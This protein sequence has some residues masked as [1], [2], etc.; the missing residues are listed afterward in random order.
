MDNTHTQELISLDGESLTAEAVFRASRDSAFVA[1][2]PSSRE[3]MAASRDMLEAWVKEGRIMY[4]ITRGFGR[5][6]STLIPPSYQEELQKNLIRSHAAN[7]GSYFSK[8]E[9]RAAMLLRLN[10]FAKGYSAIRLETADLLLAFLNKGIH[11]RIPQWG[12]VGA[13]GDLNPSAHIA[14]SLMGEGEVEY[15]G[16]VM[17]AEAALSA[18]HLTPVVFRAKEGLALIN[19][20][21][22]MTGVGVLQIADAWALV[23]TAEILTALAIEALKGSREPF[24]SFAHLAKPH[25][26]RLPARPMLM[27]VWMAAPCLGQRELSAIQQ[28]LRTLMNEKNEV[29]DSV[30]SLQAAH[31]LRATPQILRAVRDALT[32]VTERRTSEMT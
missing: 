16:N 19:G 25:L 13:S 21:T 31:T 5:F 4:E 6:V 20:T 7:V 11:P 10:A 22:M 28:N 29:V 8:E 26:A 27:T 14:L 1:I 24:Q 32:Y 15:G 2:S 12:S 23:R 18:A 30:I 3:K 17:T 9:T